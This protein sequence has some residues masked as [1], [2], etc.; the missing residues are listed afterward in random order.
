MERSGIEGEDDHWA[1]AGNASSII[2]HEGP[3][4][5]GHALP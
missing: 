4:A 5:H 1:T 3:P 2:L